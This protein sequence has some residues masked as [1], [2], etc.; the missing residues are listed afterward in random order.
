MSK[1]NKIRNLTSMELNQMK[2]KGAAASM[3]LQPQYG[4]RIVQMKNKTKP[5]RKMKHKGRAYE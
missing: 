1:K 4:Q 3:V 2:H 5:V